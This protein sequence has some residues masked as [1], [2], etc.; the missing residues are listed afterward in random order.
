MFK[1]FKTYPIF[2]KNMYAWRFDGVLS[3]AKQRHRASMSFCMLLLRPRSCCRKWGE[4]QGRRTCRGGNSLRVFGPSATWKS[5]KTWA[6]AMSMWTA[7]VF[8]QWC[9]RCTP[10]SDRPNLIMKRFTANDG[11]MGIR[12]D[13]HSDMHC[14]RCK[15]VW[16]LLLHYVCRLFQDSFDGLPCSNL[17]VIYIYICIYNYTFLDPFGSVSLDEN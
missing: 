8:R 2:S 16:N 4:Y 5:I 13:M 12:T 9:T 15:K 17:D 11:M 6:E 3:I 14:T 10:C 1:D 7:M